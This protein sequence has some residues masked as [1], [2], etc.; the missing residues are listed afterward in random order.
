MYDWLK[1]RKCNDTTYEYK[2]LTYYVNNHKAVAT[3]LNYRTGVVEL[4]PFNPQA[5]IGSG[6]NGGTLLMDFN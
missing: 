6:F 3:Y 1:E 4:T 5:D 2:N